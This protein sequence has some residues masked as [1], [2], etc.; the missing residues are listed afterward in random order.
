[1]FQ[2]DENKAIQVAYKMGFDAGTDFSEERLKEAIEQIRQLKEERD[3]AFKMSRCECGEDECCANLVKHRDRSDRLA[4]ALVEI[5]RKTKGAPVFT[6]EGEIFH[7][8]TMAMSGG[9][10]G[11]DSA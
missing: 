9:S 2:I 3:E 5:I 1:M 10:W 8:A 6:N 11:G 7:I 4:S